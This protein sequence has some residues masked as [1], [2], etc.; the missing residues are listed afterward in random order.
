MYYSR[1]LHNVCDTLVQGGNCL[2]KNIR[3]IKGNV[4]E[5]AAGNNCVPLI[6]T[7]EPKLFFLFFL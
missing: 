5:W 3:G 7:I 1:I 6:T 2:S 4:F